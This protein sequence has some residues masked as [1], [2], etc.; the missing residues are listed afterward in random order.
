PW[1]HQ[2]LCTLPLP[3]TQSPLCAYTS[4][5]FASGR[6]IS[7]VTTPKLAAHMVSLSA[8]TDP[9]LLKSNG[10]NE[11][12]TLWFTSSIPNKGI[13]TLALHDLIPGTQILRYTPAFLA[14]LE[15]DLSTLDRESLW[16]TAIARLPRI[17]RDSFLSLMY[18]YGDPRVRHQDIVKGNTFQL[19]LAGANHLAIF[20]ES[21]RLNHDCA[22][23]AQYV[24]DPETL[25]HTVRVMRPIPEGEE[26]TIA[27]TSPLE[28]TGER[29]ARLEE[30]FHF[31]CRCARCGD[32]ERGDG[33]LDRIREMQ[34]QLND[35]SETSQATPE[36]ARQ[37]V[38][39]YEEEG[40]QGFMDVPYGFAALACN[41]VGQSAEARA[42]AGRARDAVLGKDGT[43]A[44]ALRIWDSL[45]G[46]AERHW[47]Y[48]RR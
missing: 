21:S 43:G 9:A 32:A 29:R 30:G 36:L 5:T 19:E 11:A 37:L 22:P 17:T 44:A 15:A 39:L 27:Y 6:G 16:S 34:A 35:W 25:T 1:T 33:M 26:V 31:K 10:T 3:S 24:V 14:Y 41:A 18:I 20:P 40:L 13:G 8:F 23:N 47:S 46:D 45:L 38:D 48:R 28:K 4:T 42:W 12:S 7:I 2:P